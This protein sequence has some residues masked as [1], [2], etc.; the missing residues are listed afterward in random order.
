[1]PVVCLADEQSRRPVSMSLSTLRGTCF[2]SCLWIIFTTPQPLGLELFF[3]CPAFFQIAETNAPGHLY[4]CEHAFLEIRMRTVAYKSVRSCVANS[5]SVFGWGARFRCWERAFE[6]W[7]DSWLH[8]ARVR[9]GEGGIDSWSEI[10]LVW[11]RLQSVRGQLDVL[12]ESLKLR[13]E[14]L[15]GKGEI[16][17]TWARLWSLRRQLLVLSES[18]SER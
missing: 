17:L 1:M 2:P 10:S 14:N 18:W 13:G 6:A 9:T 12:S 3:Q 11:A 7:G 16:W 8:W 4:T 15:R 5:C